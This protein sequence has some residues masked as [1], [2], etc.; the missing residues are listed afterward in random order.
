MRKALSYYRVKRSSLY[1]WLKCFDELGEDG[2]REQGARW[3]RRYNSALRMVLGLVSPDQTEFAKLREL[4][5][6]A[7]EIRCRRLIKCLASSDS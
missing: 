7:G 2:P 1:R 4:A 5:D 6:T 3:M